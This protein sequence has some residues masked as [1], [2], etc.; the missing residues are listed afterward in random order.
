MNTPFAVRKIGHAVLFVSDLER[1]KRFYTEVL[2]LKQVGID[3]N[4]FEIG[5]H[6]LLA[7]QL[8]ARVR[9]EF[10]AELSLRQIFEAPTIAELAGTL[11]QRPQSCDA[12]LPLA[13]ARITPEQAQELLDRFDEL[14]DKEVELLLQ[15]VSPESG[16]K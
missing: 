14:S 3:D 4:F 13:R 5:G 6:S 7:M 15:Q 9:K 16:G 2:G 8:M 10:Q 12:P 11:I 1:S